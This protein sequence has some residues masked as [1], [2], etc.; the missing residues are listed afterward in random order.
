MELLLQKKLKDGVTN[1]AAQT[2]ALCINSYLLSLSSIK[3]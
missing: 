3:S 1:D 2:I